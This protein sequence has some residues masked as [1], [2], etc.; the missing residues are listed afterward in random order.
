MGRTAAPRRIHQARMDRPVRNNERNPAVSGS[1]Q[2]E[3]S[4]TTLV[5]DGELRRARPSARPPRRA[6]T[7]VALERAQAAVAA[8]GHQQ[9][10]L[11]VGPEVCQRRVTELMHGPAGLRDEQLGGAAVRQPRAPGQRG[12]CRRRPAR[13]P[14]SDAGS[15]G[16][17]DR[18]GGRRSGVAAAGR[19]PSR[20]T[21]S[22]RRRPWSACGRAWRGCRDPRRSGVY[23]EFARKTGVSRRHRRRRRAER[24]EAALRAAPCR[25]M[26]QR[27]TR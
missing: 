13:G 5:S 20:R 14:G 2:A 23:R 9:R 1:P 19:C 16:T 4:P 27:S 7:R 11:H 8:L 22:R 6:R 17:P 15:T 10:Q 12:V 3:I 25:R 18:R 24:R 26:E 21:A